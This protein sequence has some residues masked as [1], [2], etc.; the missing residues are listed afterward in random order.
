LEIAD[1]PTPV[2]YRTCSWTPD[3]GSPGPVASRS[4]TTP[5]TVSCAD[6]EGGVE[7]TVG[8]LAGLGVVGAE[9]ATPVVATQMTVH[10]ITTRGRALRAIEELRVVT[11]PHAGV[12]PIRQGP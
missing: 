10:R 11:S 6:D 9:H 8:D 2:L 3:T 4:R 5:R 7:V 1:G 12:A